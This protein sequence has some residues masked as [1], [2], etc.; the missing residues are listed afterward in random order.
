ME[1]NSNQIQKIIPHRHPFLLV[2][3]IL[4]YQPG[5]GRRVSNA[6]PR[7]STFLRAFPAAARN[8]RVLIIEALAQVARWFCPQGKPRQDGVSAGLGTRGLSAGLCPATLE[9]EVEMIKPAGTSGLA[10]QSLP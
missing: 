3:R 5:K 2:D 7:T 4:D 8:A 1:L 9:L 6:L 10:P